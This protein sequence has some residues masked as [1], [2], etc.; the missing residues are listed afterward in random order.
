MKH[1]YRFGLQ[2][3]VEEFP[4][5]TLVVR[6]LLYVRKRIYNDMSVV[7]FFL[8]STSI[9]KI[10][11]FYFGL[12]SHYH[13]LVPLRCCTVCKQITCRLSVEIKVLPISSDREYVCFNRT[14]GVPERIG[15]KKLSNSK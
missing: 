5:L 7:V 1:I 10:T 11:K 4:V 2:P 3:P 12:T 8:S 15:S 6:R 9:I 13:P 14:N